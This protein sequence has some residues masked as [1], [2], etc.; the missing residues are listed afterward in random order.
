[1][2]VSE[3]KSINFIRLSALDKLIQDGLQISG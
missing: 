2:T 1:V 3:R